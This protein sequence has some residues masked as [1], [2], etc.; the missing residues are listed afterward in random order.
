MQCQRLPARHCW[1]G[2]PWRVTPRRARRRTPGV[3]D[4]HTRT[5]QRP[6]VVKPKRE[7]IVQINRLMRPVKIAQTD[8]DNTGFQIR[9]V[10]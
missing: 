6:V 8:M 7:Q 5:D 10:I 2:G 9:P 4:P 3:A 1:H